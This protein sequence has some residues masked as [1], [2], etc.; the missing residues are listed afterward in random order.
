MMVLGVVLLI[1]GI[2]AKLPILWMIGV[3]LFAFGAGLF[4]LGSSSR[5]IG[6]RRHY[7]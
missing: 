6:G 7:F 1:I 2:V 3:L 4:V 5:P